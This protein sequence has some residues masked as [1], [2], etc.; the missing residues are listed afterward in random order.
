MITPT[1]TL[2]PN[3]VTFTGSRDLMWTYLWGGEGIQPS[4]HE[5]QTVAGRTQ[6]FLE[7]AGGELASKAGGSARAFRVPLPGPQESGGEVGRTKEGRVRETHAHNS[8]SPSSCF[9]SLDSLKKL[10]PYGGGSLHRPWIS[11]KMNFPVQH[12][13]L[14]GA[15]CG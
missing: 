2:S 6:S 11:Q 14:A 1:K 5:M 13:A 9:F 3:N 7:E 4:R 10:T 15:D 12:G 8:P